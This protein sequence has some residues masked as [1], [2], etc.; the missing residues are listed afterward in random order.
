MLLQDVLLEVRLKGGL[1]KAY[2]KEFAAV[3]QSAMS[4]L[5]QASEDHLHV[6]IQLTL[7]AESFGLEA[8]AEVVAKDSRLLHGQLQVGTHRGG[9]G[10]LQIMQC[11]SFMLCLLHQFALLFHRC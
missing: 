5:T 8:A 6:M 2:P 7:F 4:M 3:R 9:W 1:L 11:H 10:L